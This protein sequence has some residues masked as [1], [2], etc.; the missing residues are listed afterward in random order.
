MESFTP[1]KPSEMNTVETGA[2][3]PGATG[4]WKAD[5][6]CPVT[7]GLSTILPSSSNRPS[8]WTALAAIGVSAKPA[9]SAVAMSR[10][11]Q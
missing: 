5:Q 10:I 8:S 1:L 7:A 3:S 4:P 6:S 9:T 2:V 11:V